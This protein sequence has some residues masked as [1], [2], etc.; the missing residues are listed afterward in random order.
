MFDAGR[1]IM[2]Q[3]ARSSLIAWG[4][5]QGG[6]FG[7]GPDP[8][9]C[10]TVTNQLCTGLLQHVGSGLINTD[11]VLMGRAIIAHTLR[12]RDAVEAQLTY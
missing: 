5:P 11:L 4:R 12:L 6:G 2:M 10:R 8:S 3:V 7:I 9:L 1:Q